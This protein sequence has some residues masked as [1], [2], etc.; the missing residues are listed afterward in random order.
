MLHPITWL[1]TQ[2]KLLDFFQAQICSRPVKEAH[3]CLYKEANHD[4][5]KQSTVPVVAEG[6]GGMHFVA[7]APTKKPAKFHP[8]PTFPSWGKSGRKFQPSNPNPPLTLSDRAEIHKLRSPRAQELFREISARSDNSFP[9]FQKPRIAT[10]C[11]CSPFFPRRL[12]VTADIGS[13][14]TKTHSTR[15]SPSKCP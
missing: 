8:S 15:N 7:R 4:N 1:Q 10:Y 13:E 3:S 5:A 2:K 12:Q 14:C 9:V 6:W 11:S